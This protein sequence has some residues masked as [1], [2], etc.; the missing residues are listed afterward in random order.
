GMPFRSI[1]WMRMTSTSCPSSSAD[2]VLTRALRSSLRRK[3]PSSLKILATTASLA[4][5]GF[6]GGRT[7]TRGACST[8]GG[9]SLRGTA[10]EG[11]AG[12]TTTFTPVSVT[13]FVGAGFSFFM[14][15]MAEPP[16]CAEVPGIARAEHE[17][18]ARAPPRGVARA[19]PV[20]T[21]R[22]VDEQT[23]DLA[24]VLSHVLDRAPEPELV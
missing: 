20:V 18:D 5:C 2:A 7:T 15:D 9:G 22:L 12:R 10:C 3:S 6:G 13:I 23:H 11:G 17:H 24:P 21:L 1:S 4:S 8:G 19:S 14:G 16:S